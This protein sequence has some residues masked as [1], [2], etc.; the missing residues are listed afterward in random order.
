MQISLNFTKT[1][2]EN[3]ATYFEKAK[4]AKKKFEGAKKA[5]V[6]STQKLEEALKEKEKT[7]LEI[8]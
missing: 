1:V 3:A 4:K 8:S 7:D 6:I 2:H 5:L